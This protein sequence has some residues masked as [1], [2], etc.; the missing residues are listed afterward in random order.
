MEGFSRKGHNHIRCLLSMS[1]DQVWAQREWNQIVFSLTPSPPHE[2]IKVISSR[3]YEQAMKSPQ[4][5][6]IIDSPSTWNIHCS[7]PE[8]FTNF[9]LPPIH[10]SDEITIAPVRHSQCWWKVKRKD[11]AHNR[12]N[13]KQKRSSTMASELSRFQKFTSP[14]P[15]DQRE[16]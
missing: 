15:S 4:R 7:T 3:I 2:V 16:Y 9:F 12:R 8:P 11:G 1:L 6:C 10:N 5:P 14:N 13:R